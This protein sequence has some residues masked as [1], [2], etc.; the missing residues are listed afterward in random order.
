MN[1]ASLRFPDSPTLLEEINLPP[2]VA[3]SVAGAMVTVQMLPEERALTRRIEPNAVGPHDTPVLI[4]QDGKI[5]NDYRPVRVR[6]T[7]PNGR[8]W[9]IPRH[10]LKYVP[11]GPS[12]ALRVSRDV[13]FTGTNTD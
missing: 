8:M 13:V 2:E 6:F 5:W 11:Q 1:T 10:W 3:N 4:D 9:R 7:D 12:Q